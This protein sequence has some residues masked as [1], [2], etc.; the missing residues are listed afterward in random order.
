[1]PRPP[2]FPIV[3]LLMSNACA[4]QPCPPQ[5]ALVDTMYELMQVDAAQRACIFLPMAD[6]D[7]ATVGSLASRVHTQ[8]KNAVPDSQG[9]SRCRDCAWDRGRYLLVRQPITEGGRDPRANATATAARVDLSWSLWGEFFH[10]FRNDQIHADV[11]MPADVEAILQRFHRADNRGHAYYVDRPVYI[12]PMITLHVGHILIDLIEQVYWSMM[13][14]Y[15]RVR[16][17]ALLILDVANSDEREVLQEKIYVNT[18]NPEVDTFG[19]IV[20]LFTD[21]PIFAAD[22]LLASMGAHG[23]FVLFRDLHVGLDVADT[24]YYRGYSMHPHVFPSPSE[25]REVQLLAARYRNF[26]AF[27]RDGIQKAF[28]S[29]GLDAVCT[30]EVLDKHW[31]VGA[32]ASASA[33]APGARQRSARVLFVQ[34]EKN[35]AILDVPAL[36][37]EVE[38]RGGIASVNELANVAFTEQLCVFDSTDVLVATAGTAIHN[39]LFMRP[40]STVGEPGH[41]IT[42]CQSRFI[43]T[44]SFDL[45]RW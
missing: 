41:L 5:P 13:K 1:M 12:L 2:W 8:E 39:M 19:A 23:D 27:M 7:A 6:L 34:R 37:R 9:W 21:M 11:V 45:C 15:G 33:A 22:N 30:P 38:A 20:R 16:R 44:P 4:L 17:D 35:R 42:A 28:V 25:S 24:Y 3:V 10:W 31:G 18:Y 26:S 29:H 32:G 40:S 14:T 36:V 43:L